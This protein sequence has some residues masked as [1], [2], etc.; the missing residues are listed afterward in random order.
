MRLI[1]VHD[2]KLLTLDS[3]SPSPGRAERAFSS[4][5]AV[6]HAIAPGGAFA[7]RAV[8]EL[9]TEPSDGKGM[10]VAMLLSRMAGEGTRRVRLGGRVSSD[11]NTLNASAKADPTGSSAEIRISDFGFRISPG[12]IIW[13]DPA[14]ELYPPA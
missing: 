1:A 5:L 8:H 7:R 2:G 9:L 4:G 14:R 12:A 11:E 10:F 3:N 6:L 13:C